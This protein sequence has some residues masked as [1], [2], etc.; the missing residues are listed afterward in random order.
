MIADIA[1]MGIV[2]VREGPHDGAGFPALLE[3]EQLP[4]PDG[5]EKRLFAARAVPEDFEDVDLS[6][7]DKARHLGPRRS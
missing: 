2:E 1:Q 7:V 6:E 5:V 3:V 4:A